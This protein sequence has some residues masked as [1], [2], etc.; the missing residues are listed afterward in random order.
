MDIHVCIEWA[1]A[2]NRPYYKIRIR[3]HQYAQWLIQLFMS[4]EYALTPVMYLPVW[5][6]NQS[7]FLNKRF[8]TFMKFK[9]SLPYLD[10]L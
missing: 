1:P 6:D 8:Q 5:T 9:F 2:A 3:Y 10:S 7:V 4:S